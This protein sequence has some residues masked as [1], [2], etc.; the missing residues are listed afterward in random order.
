MHECCHDEE[1]AYKACIKRIK[2]KGR[3]NCK[4]WYMDM[5]ECID[6]NSA[7]LIFKTLK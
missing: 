4:G 6:I 7:S 5:W 2:A 3:G 1:N